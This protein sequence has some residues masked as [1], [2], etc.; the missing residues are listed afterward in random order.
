[1]RLNGLKKTIN[2]LLH[3]NLLLIM[4][5]RMLTKSLAM[6]LVVGIASVVAG[7]GGRKS[8]TAQVTF[9]TQVAT[10]AK[11]ILDNS[12]EQFAASVTYP[13]E[14]PYPLHDIMDSVAMI[15]YYPTM[16]DDSL[17]NVV[18]QSS[19]TLWHLEGWRGWTL[20]DGSYLW[21]DCGKIY[22]V[23]YLSHRESQ[24]LDSL[25][26]A[27]IETLNPE[28]RTGWTPVTCIVDS[29]SSIVFRIDTRL[30]GDTAVYRLAGYRPDQRH[31]DHP[32]LMLYGVLDLDGSMGNRIYHFTDSMGIDAEYIPDMTDDTMP[33][34][35]VRRQGRNIHYHGRP[36]YW[37]DHLK[38][39][40]R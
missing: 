27:E 11:A 34:L 26:R 23:N 14:R 19:D 32:A 37:L 17:R 36:A 13:L 2:I 9:P 20:A 39:R 1:M 31:D 6:M 24:M 25:R 15:S 10:P 40:S 33:T 18:A 12:P 8:P 35:E 7:C 28:L 16:V 38:H 21:I 29:T 22:A 30:Q 5:G 3:R 4:P